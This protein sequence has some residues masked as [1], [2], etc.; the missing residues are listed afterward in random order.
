MAQAAP[1]SRV[2]TDGSAFTK[3]I[4]GPTDDAEY[5]N[6]ENVNPTVEGMETESETA[7]APL[8]A[9]ASPTAAQLSKLD[10]KV[11]LKRYLCKWRDVSHLHVSWE[12]AAA[13]KLVLG[14][15]RA[16]QALST[17]TTKDG[18]DGFLNDFGLHL[19]LEYADCD[20]DADDT[21]SP[22][23]TSGDAAAG[24]D[25]G[26]EDGEG[27][28][29][30]K[31]TSSLPAGGRWFTNALYVTPERVLAADPPLASS[32]LSSL[33]AEEHTAATAR[34]EEQL[35]RVKWCGLPYGCATWEKLSE[36]PNGTMAFDAFRQR[37]VNRQESPSASS[38][39][40][41]ASEGGSIEKRS[42]KG[43]K[44][45]VKCP[46]FQFLCFEGF[47]AFA[48]YCNVALLLS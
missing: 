29:V 21:S 20:L 5:E 38:G 18:E 46:S 37:A 1:S 13:L 41:N 7:A 30:D 10:N 19:D 40:G 39:S 16:T 17:F 2:G 4:Y 42:R 44:N 22:S 36:V 32:S 28:G 23:G 31:K 8:G 12:T 15:Q 35:V 14:S 26:G 27:L 48:F 9:A 47:F 6:K 3:R 24:A 34:K 11:P 33:S 45:K 43:K 25:G